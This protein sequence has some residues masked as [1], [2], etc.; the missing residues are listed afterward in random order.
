MNPILQDMRLGTTPIQQMWGAYKSAQNPQAFLENMMRQN[1]MLRQMIS[2][3]DPRQT[4]YALC[5][6]RGIDPD[7]ILSQLK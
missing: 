1:P 4:F 3:G 2:S 7:S 6:Q 5:Q